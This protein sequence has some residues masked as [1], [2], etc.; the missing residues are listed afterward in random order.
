MNAPP[1]GPAAISCKRF[2]LACKTIADLNSAYITEQE[3]IEQLDHQPQRGGARA[4]SRDFSCRDGF[5]D[6]LSY[7]RSPYFVLKSAKPCFESRRFGSSL[8]LCQPRPQS[9][10]SGTSPP[11]FLWSRSISRWIDR[12]RCVMRA[13]S[14][15]Q[16]RGRRTDSIRPRSSAPIK[17]CKTSLN[18]KAAGNKIPGTRPNKIATP[19]HRTSTLPAPR[20]EHQRDVN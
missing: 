18:S 5:S 3:K 6:I 7:R 19:R 2:Q 16:T 4:G 11:H 13:R 1:C 10:P 17:K 14:P 8:W 20:R 15:K 9:S 12:T